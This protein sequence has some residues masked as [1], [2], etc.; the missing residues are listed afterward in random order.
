M[1]L[2]FKNEIQLTARCLSWTAGQILFRSVYNS[3]GTSDNEDNIILIC[4]TCL[5]MRNPFCE[6]EV[7]SFTG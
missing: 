2:G 3:R 7:V 4:F 1:H 5:I 6:M